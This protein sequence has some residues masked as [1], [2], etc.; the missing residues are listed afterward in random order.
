MTAAV[1]AMTSVLCAS[2]TDSVS[3]I[4]LDRLSVAKSGCRSV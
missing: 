4:K 3:L 1:A 2:T